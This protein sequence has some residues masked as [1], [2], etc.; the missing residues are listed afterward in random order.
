MTQNINRLIVGNGDVNPKA[1]T[2]GP[3][4]K[5]NKSADPF[6]AVGAVGANKVMCNRS[7]RSNSGSRNG[8][9]EPKQ[10]TYIQKLLGLN[11]TNSESSSQYPFSIPPWQQLLKNKQDALGTQPVF[12]EYNYDNA[13][14]KQIDSSSNH[15]TFKRKLSHTIHQEGGHRH[16]MSK[17]ISNSYGFNEETVSVGDIGNIREKKYNGVFSEDG[18]REGAQHTDYA[19]MN[20]RRT[21]Y[22]EKH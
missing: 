15:N 6:S 17:V 20:E 18:A 14:S 16:T 11:R 7:N 13:K 9:G 1:L 3:A 21:I 22:T 8:Q 5:R 12:K 10:P 4:Y 19:D 2:Y